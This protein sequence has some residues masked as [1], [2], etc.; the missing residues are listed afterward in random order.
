MLERFKERGEC[1]KRGW[2]FWQIYQKSLSCLLVFQG[3]EQGTGEY[4]CLRERTHTDNT[5]LSFTTF[6]VPYAVLRYVGGQFFGVS[7]WLT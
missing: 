3:Y 7:C 6:R 2:D 4:F 1:W 5:Q